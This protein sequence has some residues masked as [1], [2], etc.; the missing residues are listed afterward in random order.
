MACATKQDELGQ[1]VHIKGFKDSYFTHRM[2][3][4]ES[5]LHLLQVACLKED[6]AVTFVGRKLILRPSSKVTALLF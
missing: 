5:K 3:A 2:L 1:V 6:I 4:S